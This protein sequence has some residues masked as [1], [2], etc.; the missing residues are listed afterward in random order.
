MQQIVGHESG[1]T[2]G[3]LRNPIMKNL[4]TETVVSPKGLKLTVSYLDEA[5]KPNKPIEGV[6]V[7][8][9]VYV[10]ASTNIRRR[11]RQHLL[12]ALSGRHINRQLQ[13]HL[14]EKA[15]LG[16]TVE[17]EVVSRN[18]AEEGVHIDA[19]MGS[20]YNSPNHGRPYQL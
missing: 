15:V 8:D 5:V 3:N 1:N 17:I 20:I 2:Q 18:P 12:D 19:R 14:Y 16:R 9:G 6:Y 10:G 4:H 13:W 11:I 7:I